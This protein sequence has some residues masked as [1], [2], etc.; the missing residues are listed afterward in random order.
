V[1]VDTG[2]NVAAIKVER[3]DAECP[4]AALFWQKCYYACYPAEVPCSCQLPS[5]D[6]SLWL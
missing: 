4:K 1:C 5:R 3:T 2:C 6:Y